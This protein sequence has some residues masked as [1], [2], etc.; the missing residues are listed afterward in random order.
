[1]ELILKFFILVG[2]L[3]GAILFFVKR[4]FDT[5]KQKAIDSLNDE[6]SKANAKQAE[7]SRKIKDADEELEKRKIEVKE[8]TDK[9][10]QEADEEIKA[11][12][13]KT[14]SKAREEGEEIITKAQNAKDKIRQEIQADFDV[15][16]IN[17]SMEIL[18]EILSENAKGALNE[19]LISEFLSNL[20]DTDM[21]RIDDKIKS[22]D[23]ITVAALDAKGKEKLTDIISKKM[24]RKIDVKLVTDPKIGGG[25]LLKFG[26]MALDGSIKKSILEKGLALQKQATVDL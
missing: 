10:R 18:N 24:N 20:E 25:V 19:V 21:S 1:M 13:D 2:L 9:L 22:I 23:V 11:E 15:K 6:I 3:L 26:S 14:V 12:R 4:V 5:S 8:L 16:L 17:F 7:L